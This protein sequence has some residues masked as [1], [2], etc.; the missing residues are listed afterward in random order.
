MMTQTPR[1]D[2]NDHDDSGVGLL[3]HWHGHH[4]GRAPERG[5]ARMFGLG[6]VEVELGSR[7]AGTADTCF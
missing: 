7:A 5:V 4:G 3:G 6:E 2:H 1:L